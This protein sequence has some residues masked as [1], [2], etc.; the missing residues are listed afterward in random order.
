[1][2]ALCVS[3]QEPLLPAADTAQT[4]DST[5]TLT[6]LD[7]KSFRCH[8]RFARAADRADSFLMNEP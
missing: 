7:A 2:T 8:I 5:S 4:V 3:G 6:C 1:M